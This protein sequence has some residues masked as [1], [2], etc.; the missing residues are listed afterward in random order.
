[1]RTKLVFPLHLLCLCCSRHIIDAAA[2]DGGRKLLNRRGSKQ[3]YAAEVKD[4]AHEAY[5]ILYKDGVGLEGEPA[6]DFGTFLQELQRMHHTLEMQA[7][8]SVKTDAKARKRPSKDRQRTVLEEVELIA[9]QKRQRHA[10]SQNLRS[11]K[12]RKVIADASAHPEVV[13]DV[14]CA[15][16][17]Y[18]HVFPGIHGCSPGSSEGRACMRRVE[19]GFA[20]RK[21]QKAIIKM[22]ERKFRSVAPEHG[23]H[24][25]I[26]DL[27]N[28]VRAGESGAAQ[29]DNLLLRLLE[30]A[31]TILQVEKLYYTSVLL[32]R[33]DAS[34]VDDASEF[35]SRPHADKANNENYDWSGVLYLSSVNQDFRGGELVFIDADIDRVVRPVRGRFLLFSSGLENVH[36]VLPM[37]DGLRYVVSFWFTCNAQHEHPIFNRSVLSKREEL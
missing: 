33:V 9:A 24:H 10:I 11:R 14:P 31:Q 21:E 28:R 6:L 27:D 3:T 30:R 23:L 1:M 37:L 16:P 17:L 20:T 25:M 15:E 8:S 26:P 34:K 22:M 19:D 2:E 12:E 32:Q 5:S 13:W 18:G 7:N 4:I 35:V 36:R 29:L